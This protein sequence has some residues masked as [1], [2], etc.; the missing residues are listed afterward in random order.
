MQKDSS[1][2]DKTQES[3]KLSKGLSV[4][5]YARK[6][7]NFDGS[8]LTQAITNCELVYLTFAIT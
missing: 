1:T 2:H 3:A 6:F 4:S 5:R 8:S 7:D